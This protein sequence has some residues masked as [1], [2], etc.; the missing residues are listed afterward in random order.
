M[1][2]AA[3]RACQVPASRQGFF[4]AAFFTAFFFQAPLPNRATKHIMRQIQS[5]TM[6][7]QTPTAPIPICTQSTQLRP[8]RQTSIEAVATTI[9]NRTSL[10]ARRALGSTKDR[11][12]SRMAKPAWIRTSSSESTIVSPDSA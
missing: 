11:V 2:K 12:H 3:G 8:M 7:Y 1:G 6:A 5:T 4:Y 9:V 10:A